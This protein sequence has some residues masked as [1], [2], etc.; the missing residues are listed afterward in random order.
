[1][2]TIMKKSVDLLDALTLLVVSL[3]ESSRAGRAA[4]PVTQQW[5][6]ARRSR[7]RMTHLQNGVG[8]LLKAMRSRR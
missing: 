6:R 3:I 5:L 4:E 2:F 7:R 1:L 8:L